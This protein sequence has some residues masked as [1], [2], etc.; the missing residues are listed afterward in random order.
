VTF[1]LNSFGVTFSLTYDKRE[2]KLLTFPVW[3]IMD[4]ESRDTVT[5]IAAKLHFFLET[6]RDV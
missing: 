2:S 4:N 6:R 3:T 1:S 5:D